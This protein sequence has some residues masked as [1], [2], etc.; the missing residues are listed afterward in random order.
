[1]SRD[2]GQSR[3]SYACTCGRFTFFAHVNRKSYAKRIECDAEG[4]D[5]DADGGGVCIFMSERA[6]GCCKSAAGRRGADE[7]H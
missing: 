5:A 4:G 7:L 2:Y 1:M 3:N 6:S